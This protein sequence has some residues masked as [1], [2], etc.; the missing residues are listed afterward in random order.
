[1]S[2]LLKSLRV[3][4]LLAT[5]ALPSSALCQMDRGLGARVAASRHEMGRPG[6]GAL[7]G[8]VGTIPLS[9]R[10]LTE[11]ALPVMWLHR[12]GGDEIIHETP[13][14]LPDL[15]LQLHLARPPVRPYVGVGMGGATPIVFGE[16]SFR[17]TASAS[18]GIRMPTNR[19]TLQLDIRHRRIIKPHFS[20]PEHTTD[21]GL[22]ILGTRQQ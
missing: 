4:A 14:F 13:L 15:Q 21:I 18:A 12:T 6:S 17:A 8:I 9:S 2:A 19:A 3:V 11:I 20:L 7:L 1:M 10:V 16:F 5:F 22:S